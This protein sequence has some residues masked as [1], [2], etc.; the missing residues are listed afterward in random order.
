MVALVASPATVTLLPVQLQTP[1]EP[2]A[3]CHRDRR[4]ALSAPAFAG[5]R[6][7]V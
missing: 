5:A 7:G 6:A 2:V 4:G 3:K 1:V